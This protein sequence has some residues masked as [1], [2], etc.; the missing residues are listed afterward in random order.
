MENPNL[1]EASKAAEKAYKEG[2]KEAVAAIV[3]SRVRHRADNDFR[4]EQEDDVRKMK[5]KKLRDLL[6]REKVEYLEH[7]VKAADKSEDLISID[8]HDDPGHTKSITADFER[9][10]H[11]SLHTIRGESPILDK[12]R[13][14]RQQS[15][16]FGENDVFIKNVTG[17]KLTKI[18]DVNYERAKRKYNIREGEFMDELEILQ[19]MFEDELDD[20]I[21]TEGQNSEYKKYIKEHI[22]N[23]QKGY[24]W[25]K[26][27]LP[28]LFEDRKFTEKIGDYLTIKKHDRSK[29]N[30]KDELNAYQKHFYGKPE[31]KEVNRPEFDKA[32]DHHQK[33]NKH[34]WQYWVLVRGDGS[35]KT[36]D[37]P[38]RYIIE[39]I[40]D[41]WSFSWKSG[42]LNEIFDWWNKNKSGMIL[43]QNTRNTVE[44]ILGKMK[45]KLQEVGSEVL[46]EDTEILTESPESR[47]KRLLLKSISFIPEDILNK[48][49][50]ELREKTF[51]DKVRILKA[52]I[53]NLP[54]DQLNKL[55]T[56]DKMVALEKELKEQ[57]TKLGKCSLAIGGGT[58]GGFVG[59]GAGLL[60][61]ASMVTGWDGLG[62][63]ILAICSGYGALGAAA[64][65]VIG[66]TVGGIMNAVRTKKYLK[67]KTPEVINILKDEGILT[68]EFVN[69]YLDNYTFLNENEFADDLMTIYGNKFNV[70]EEGKEDIQDVVDQVKDI[71]YGFIDKRNG[72]RI[73][74]REWIHG[75][76]DLGTYYDTNFDPRITLKN[77]LGICLDQSLAIQY[78]MNKL[79][80]NYKCDI[81]ALTKGRFGHAVPCYQEPEGKWYYFENAWDKERG[82]HGPFADEEHM[83][84]YLDMIYHKHHD[85]DNDD[86]VVVRTYREFEGLTES[87]QFK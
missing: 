57:K 84:R 87:V 20:E 62:Y 74:D 3:A 48:N 60:V 72:N 78:L 26:K 80:P 85:K 5:L 32:W 68:E 53:S 73:D 22:S 17:E 40:C 2:K 28:E 45:K 35:H 19:E 16:G 7:L 50:P 76:K 34:H 75:C 54:K 51:E 36:L 52:R 29:Y 44:M 18:V 82:L 38:Y 33:I 77:K 13:K 61:K 31:E 67:E 59:T 24:R 41:W 47:R 56:S 1:N 39:M 46:K 11:I 65:G 25:L 6:S 14:G 8:I 66:G 23:V 83:K 27:H 15:T 86:P 64:L 42:H 49:F 9:D 10:G 4:A 81:Y 30:K 43:S 21:L 12:D 79:H 58:A 70:Q 63:V 69:E 71:V 55:L 37:I